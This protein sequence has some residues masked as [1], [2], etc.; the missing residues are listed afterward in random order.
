[1]SRD[2][3]SANSQYGYFERGDIY[4]K[5][6]NGD[7]VT[8][9]GIRSGYLLAIKPVQIT[10]PELAYKSL[11]KY[12]GGM[13]KDVFVLKASKSDDPYEEIAH[14]LDAN[15]YQELANLDLPYV[16]LVPEQWRYYPGDLLGSNILGFVGYRD[17][18]LTGQYGIERQFDSIL[19][20]DMGNLYKN[21][22]SDLFSGVKDEVFTND[23]VS[24]FIHEGSVVLTIEPKVQSMI[25]TKSDEL[26]SKWKAKKMGIL[27]IEPQTGRIVGASSRPTFNPN[28]Y[29]VESDQR[30]YQNPFVE[31]VFE[32]GSIMKP[33]TVAAGLD[34]N[35]I[36][37][38]TT[39]NDKGFLEMDGKRIEN[40]DGQGRGII[41]MQGVL[42]QS[43]NTGA[44]FVA[45]KL[46]ASRFKEYLMRFGLGDRTDIDM[47]GEVN[48][49]ISNLDSERDIEI[50]TAS[51][52]QGIAVTPI[53]MVRAL[54]ALAN[55]G[56]LIKPHFVDRIDL[57]MGISN[58]VKITEQGRAISS[59]TSD[60]ISR[61]LVKVVDEYLAGGA[62]KLEHYSIA[63]KTGTAQ[64]ANPGGG[65]Y[66]ADRYM[67]SFFGYFPAYKPRFLVFMYLYEPVGAKYSSETL[68]LP[69]KDIT[70]FLIS[71]YNIPPD[72]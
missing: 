41:N 33:I 31:D 16:S 60:E 62:I 17:D 13:S 1:L 30:V 53:S 2:Q 66:Y 39:Y 61:M 54:G 47:P 45:I 4:F 8:A 64:I 9:A 36:T 57:D 10:D 28:S 52:G 20:R 18:V 50:A 67:H 19:K 6:I 5:S 7:I 70:Q 63:A 49:L 72:R 40:Y 59:A 15:A 29:Q 26:M 51:Y 69:F 58:D 55:K 21:F 46:G 56:F 71:Y 44:S 3:V 27:I 22:F 24:G 65:G 34:A 11:E 23:E 14:R 12:L 32:M 35:V 68:S 42:N 43:L 37:A 38:D 48:N 25:E